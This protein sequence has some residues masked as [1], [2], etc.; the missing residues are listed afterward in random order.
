MQAP[1]RHSVAQARRLVGSYDTLVHLDRRD[2]WQMERTKCST[3]TSTASGLL[4]M[5]RYYYSIHRFCA[6]IKKMY[7]WIPGRNERDLHLTVSAVLSAQL[8]Q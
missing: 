4:Q 5:H 1:L 7:L 6:S 3:G 8:I 2:G